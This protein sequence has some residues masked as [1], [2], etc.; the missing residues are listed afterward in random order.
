MGKYPNRGALVLERIL[1]QFKFRAPNDL[2]F[3]VVALDFFFK[4]NFNLK[5]GVRERNII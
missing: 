5:V 1:V 2:T 4:I 3:F